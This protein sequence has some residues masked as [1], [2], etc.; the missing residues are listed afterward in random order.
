MDRFE[1]YFDAFYAFYYRISPI[2]KILGQFE[3][4]GFVIM[5]TRENIRLIARAPL[6]VSTLSHCRAG[7]A[8][9]SLRKCVDSPEPS[10]L[11]NTMNT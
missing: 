7:K 5:P 3:N 9:A 1:I 6:N 2:L 11:A 10:L 4:L 8:Q